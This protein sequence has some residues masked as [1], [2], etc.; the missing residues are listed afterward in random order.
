MK[1]FIM[2]T[3]LAATLSIGLPVF[4]AD[5]S[6][7]IT[8]GP[9][10]PPRVVYVVPATP[11]PEYIWIDGY[12]YPV[13]HHW[14]WHQGYWTRSPYM[15]ARWAAPHYERGEYFVG[16]WEGDRG[17]MEHDHHWD[18]DRDRDFRQEEHY[19]KKKRD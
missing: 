16:Y 6:V 10:P 11:G 3:L 13:G 4:G 17:R 18:H 19:R 7:G 9:P 8:I 5:V 2:M 15:G 14:K 1:T 12:W